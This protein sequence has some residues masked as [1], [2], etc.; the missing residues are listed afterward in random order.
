MMKQDCILDIAICLRGDALDPVHVSSVLGLEP[1]KSQSKGEKRI[2][3]TNHQYI[4]KMGTWILT[5]KDKSK[6]VSVLIKELTEKFNDTKPRFLDIN[7]VEEAYLDVFMAA[8]ADDEGGGT[9]EFQLSQEN[10]HALEKMALPVRFTVAV[11]KE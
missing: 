3:R 6:D 4:T 10:V 8:T 9:C 1:S 5:V 11:V 7:G 2:T